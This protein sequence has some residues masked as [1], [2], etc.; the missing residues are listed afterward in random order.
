[1]PQVLPL[2]AKVSLKNIC[3]PF[4]IS[5]ALGS[6]GGEGDGTW[7]ADI[8]TIPKKIVI[9][10]FIFPSYHLLRLEAFDRLSSW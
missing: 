9:N 1:V 10:L 2:P 6:G 3:L 5:S 4:A 7:Q 8:K